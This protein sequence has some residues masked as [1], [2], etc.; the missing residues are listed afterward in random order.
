MASP[1]IKK[2]ITALH[3]NGMD[4]RMLRLPAPKGKKRNIFL[5]Y[6]HHAS[7][8]RLTGLAE[9][10]NAHGSITMPDLPG[11]GGMD[12]F[13]KIGEK[14]TLD[15]YAD[16][17]ASLLKLYF[18]RKRITVIAM[19]FSVPLIIRTLQKYP[20]LA[21]KVDIVI[22]ISGFVHHDDFIFSKREY[23][24]LR[25]L[26]WVGSR[27]LPSLFFKYVVFSKPV[28]TAT[29]TLVGNRHSK[30]KD[31]V[32]RAERDRRIAFEANLWK[33]NDVR[34][35][36]STYGLML[37]L[38]ICNDKVA[39]PAYHVTATEDRY[40]NN[41]TVKQHLHVIFDKIE[42]ISTQMAN[43]APTIMATAKEAEPYVPARLKK[44]LG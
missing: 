43:H 32:D 11:L 18:K 24:G 9:V 16:Y 4:G 29:Y 33:I 30:M 41:E 27:K 28:I 39:A 25:T 10:L 6:G 35:R 31:A 8:E 1:K 7:L 40:F 22:S 17:L 14:P 19:S 44:I 13:Y 21:K 3:V 5:L 42:V 34:T 37:T 2:N 26:S 20:E 12:S 38:D 23:W 36:M 15:N